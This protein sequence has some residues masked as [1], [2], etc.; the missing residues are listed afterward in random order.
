MNWNIKG[1]SKGGNFLITHGI[2]PIL[3][4]NYTKFVPLLLA[5][6]HFALVQ[7]PWNSDLFCK[8][9]QMQNLSRVMVMEN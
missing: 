4:P 7:K 1:K 2:L 3:P 9:L 6:R 8:M 5:L